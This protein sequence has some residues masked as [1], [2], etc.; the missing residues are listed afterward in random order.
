MSESWMF[1]KEIK[2]AFSHIDSEYSVQ[3]QWILTV[4]ISL[5]CQSSMN[6]I[7]LHCISFNVR[8]ARILK[9]YTPMYHDFTKYRRVTSHKKARKPCKVGANVV[10]VQWKTY[11]F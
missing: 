8:Q 3:H 6:K 2:W 1:S 7:E 4:V 9:E 10:I 5:H 11:K